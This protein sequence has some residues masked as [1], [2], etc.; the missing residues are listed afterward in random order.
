MVLRTIYYKEF[1]HRSI[2]FMLP[3]R[4]VFFRAAILIIAILSLGHVQGQSPS[5][6]LDVSVEVFQATNSTAKNLA[7]KV[8]G[9][10]APYQIAFFPEGKNP[11]IFHGNMTT[12]EE[13][14]AKRVTVVI[15]DDAGAVI[16]KVLELK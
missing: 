11:V 3:S 6:E 10:Q 9:G 7:V 4:N 1:F 2:K 15:R 16:H 13:C 8:K 5:G 14:S 12:L